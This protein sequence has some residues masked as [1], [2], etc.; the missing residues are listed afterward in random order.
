MAD[1]LE[2][3]RNENMHLNKQNEE[4]N[5]RHLIYEQTVRN[6]LIETHKVCKS[7]KYM[8]RV[9]TTKKKSRF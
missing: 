2:R 5:N 1:D 6:K 3:I 4:I 9:Q 7:Q 8:T